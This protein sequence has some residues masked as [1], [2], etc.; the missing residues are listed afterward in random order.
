[1]KFADVKIGDAIAVPT[2]RSD[3]ATQASHRFYTVISVT[4]TQFTAAL[5]T[6]PK[7]TIK[8]RIKD[9]ML[10]GDYR[11]TFAVPATQEL[12]AQCESERVNAERHMKALLRMNELESAIQHRKLTAEQMEALADA[13]ERSLTPVHSHAFAGLKL[14]LRVGTYDDAGMISDATGAELFSVGQNEDTREM[15]ENQKAL[16][17]WILSRLNGPAPLALRSEIMAFLEEMA[18]FDLPEDG[19][20]DNHDELSALI[21]RA[22]ALLGKLQSSD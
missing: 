19:I 17:H 21:S 22:E 12:L 10:L 6:N 9:G 5:K 11:Y 1:M 14:P 20:L 18:A 15:N 4:K 13:F 2:R 3:L 7:V 16:A 8:A